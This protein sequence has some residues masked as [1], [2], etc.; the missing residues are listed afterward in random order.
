L[1]DARYGGA[2]LFKADTA[3]R[4]GVPARQALEQ[5]APDAETFARAIGLTSGLAPT[6]GR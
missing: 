4:L 2:H 1:I 5:H 3:T 6:K